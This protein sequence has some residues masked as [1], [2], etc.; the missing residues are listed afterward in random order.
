ML[1]GG[2]GGCQQCSCVPCDACTLDCQNPHS[3][4][5][6]QTV[7]HL[8]A[9]GE[10]AGNP[11]DGYLTATGDV[12][13][14]DPYDGM[15]G[16]GPWYQNVGG[17]FQWD[18]TQNRIPCVVRFSFWRSSFILGA[19]PVPPPTSTPT[20]ER[21]RVTCVEG[22]ILVGDGPL[23]DEITAGNYKDY[24]P[25]PVVAGTGDRSAYDPRSGGG[26]V[27]IRPK[28]DKANFTV[29]A[30][31]EWDKQK[32]QH[33]VYG[34]VRECYE[35]G[36][37]C[38]TY[39][40]GSA[41]PGA[42]YLKISNLSVTGASP[43]GYY[44]YYTTVNDMKSFLEKTFVLDRLPGMCSFWTGTASGGECDG[45]YG[46]PGVGLYVRAG[47]DGGAIQIGVAMGRGNDCL[48][49]VLF[50]ASIALADVP[51]CGSYSKSGTGTSIS[52]SGSPY[53]YTVTYTGSF[54][55]EITS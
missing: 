4:G 47:S 46:L 3:G 28:C 18:G 27:S 36:T 1:L 55:W 17:G 11:T 34:I 44:P 53:G 26:T 20:L 39:C 5:A 15:D 22:S 49:G 16:S 19:S 52:F 12:D 45:S 7:Y 54:D 31:V 35:V 41:P 23:A 30:R 37:P 8:Y 38:A 14:S 32:R 42:I 24:G 10:E 51:I 43:S 48:A 6:F 50:S 21:I 2:K 33:V 40:S 25:I 29:G 9:L 13:T